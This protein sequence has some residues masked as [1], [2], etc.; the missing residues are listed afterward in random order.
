MKI[1][2]GTSKLFTAFRPS[3]INF[4]TQEN[5][6]RKINLKNIFLILLKTQNFKGWNETRTNVRSSHWRC[7]VR[8]GA[9]MNLAKFTRKHL[10]QS[11]FFSKVT[12]LRPATLLKMRL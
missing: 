10:C 8:K 5:T 11:L 9:F 7:S 12:D 4:D 3:T 2:K 1:S 6:R